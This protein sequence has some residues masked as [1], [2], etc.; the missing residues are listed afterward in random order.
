MPGPQ[1]APQTT[2]TKVDPQV[3]RRLDDLH[4]AVTALQR[5]HSSLVT[6]VTTPP[7][8][9]TTAQLQQIQDALGPNGTHAL[10]AANMING[11]PITDPHQVGIVWNNN[12]QLVVSQG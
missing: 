3:N 1:S 6:L 11:L 5:A 8:T 4:S 12:G 7:T 10:F 9:V 2:R